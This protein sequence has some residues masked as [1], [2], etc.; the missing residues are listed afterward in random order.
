VNQRLQEVKTTSI[1][2]RALEKRKGRRLGWCKAGTEGGKRD[3]GK[4]EG[5][6]GWQGRLLLRKAGGWGVFRIRNEEF[7]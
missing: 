4:K 5:R 6:V 1:Q 2:N 3:K 7:F